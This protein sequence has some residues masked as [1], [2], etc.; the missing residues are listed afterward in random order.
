MT[1]DPLMLVPG[2]V[3]G[4]GCCTWG[5]GLELKSFL[6]LGDLVELTLGP[7]ELSATG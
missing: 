5:P 6:S 1:M 2:E 7:S 4:T 3:M